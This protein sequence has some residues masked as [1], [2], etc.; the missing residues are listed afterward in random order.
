MNKKTAFFAGIALLVQSLT[1]LI[2]FL[3]VMRKK[4]S[5]ASVLL[6]LAGAGSVAGGLLLYK[7]INRIKAEEVLL[8]EFLGDDE[9]QYINGEMEVLTD[10]N[11]D[12]AKFC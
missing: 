3:V 8:S 7:N 6:A 10:D 5:I 11:L 12:E 9:Y 2:T 4:K 1:I